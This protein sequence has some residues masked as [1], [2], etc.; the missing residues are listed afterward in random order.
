MTTTSRRL[1]M[2]FVALYIAIAGLLVLRVPLG[3]APDET[4][5]I[6][7]VQHLATTHSLP[8]FKPIGATKDPG[9]EF[10]QPP[11]YY[12]ISAVGWNAV[13]PGV[14][15]YACRLVSLLF[16]A[17]TILLVFGAVR[18]LFDESAA[19]LA[20]GFVAL[21]PLHI[22]VGASAGNDTA[23]GFFCA[24]LFYLV[25]RG[26][27][28]EAPSLKLSAA[29]GVAVG[30]AMLS[31]TSTLTVCLAALGWLVHSSWKSPVEID[32]TL[33]RTIF[34]R[35]AAIALTVASLICGPWLVRNTALYGDPLAVRIF[36][37]AFRNSSPRPSAFF[38]GGI[39]FL[40]YIRAL[41]LVMFCTAWGIFGGP[42]TALEVLNLFGTRGPRPEAFGALPFLLVCGGATLAALLGLRRVAWDELNSSHK[43]AW[44]WWLLG[45]LAVVAA[46]ANF[47]L[48]QFQGQ[49][50]YLHPAL[51]PLA[52]VLAL[53]WREIFPMETARGKTGTIGFALVLVGLSVWNIVSWRTLV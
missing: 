32:R 31:K 46:W 21:W 48:I 2:F 9:Y 13:G 22:N 6:Y 42:N 11:L 37:E 20:A 7:Y 27:T 35:N 44:L 41:F 49:A 19:I 51:L 40:T 45:L 24:L 15:N 34:L 12:A 50:R 52:A 26:S 36:D 25:A 39:D 18:R 1:V 4:A 47:N 30:L 53:G 38:A 33:R 14:Q 28:E 10:H 8:V 5:H 3:K 17:A 23:A 29:I 43:R 16:G